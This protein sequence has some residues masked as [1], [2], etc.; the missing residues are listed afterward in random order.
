[1]QSAAI[2]LCGSLLVDNLFLAFF[3][4]MAMLVA[5]FYAE[6]LVYLLKELL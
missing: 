2:I 1:M 6:S 3:S 4:K 5:S